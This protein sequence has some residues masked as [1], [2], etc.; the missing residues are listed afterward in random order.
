[1]HTEAS[2]DAGAGEAYEDSKLRA[3]PLRRRG[4]TVAASIVSVL[5]PEFQ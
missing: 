4:P 1:M 3:R 2:V 5:P